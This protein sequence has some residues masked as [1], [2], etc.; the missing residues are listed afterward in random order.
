MAIVF[1]NHI[2]NTIIGRGLLD[3]FN[4]DNDNSYFIATGAVTVFP[5]LLPTAATVS[6]N[7][8]NY[9]TTY[10]A[11]WP[12]VQYN[13]PLPA[14]PD[15]GNVLAMYGSPAESTAINTGTA[16]WGII[17][18]SNVNNAAIQGAILP[19]AK[20]IIGNVTI[21]SD[22]GIIRL[23]DINITSGN[24]YNLLDSSITAI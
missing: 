7:W 22:G 17:W 15:S 23:A 24:N 6:L 9:N 13:Q 18:I 16:T 4:I 12:G 2:K 21:G 1:S 14:T 19:D 5:G 10:L 8:Q 11:H 20:F 3:S